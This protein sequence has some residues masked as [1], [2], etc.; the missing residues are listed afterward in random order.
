MTD[1]I[2]ISDLTKQFE[3]ITAVNDVS[4]DVQRGEVFG[5][6]GPNAAGKSTT[7]KIAAT[8]L[9]PT[10]GTISVEGY[11]VL[12]APVDVRS[13]T[14]LLPEDG[15][16]THYDRLSAYKNLEYFGR[17]YDVPEEKLQDRIERLLEFLELSDRRDDSPATFSTGL[18]QKLSLARSMIHNPRVV[19]L[20]EPT[21]SLDPIMSKRVRDFIDEQAEVGKQTFFLCTHLLSEVEDLCDRVGF[22]SR[23]VLVEVGRP[24]DLRRKFWTVRT[25]EVQLADADLSKGR[26]IISSTGLVEAARVEKERVVFEVEEAETKNPQ[27]IRAL[28]E[29]DQ[30]IVEFRE[31]VPDLE[32]VYLKV[33]GGN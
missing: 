31:R 6:L 4:L 11:D 7:V 2:E 23:G 14:G 27:I 9:E 29:S 1:S 8:L 20:D 24:K 17:L 12:E 33:I 15:A 21:S 13:V 19:F 26:E 22:I 18:K 28:M 25:Y 30:L 3:K 32:D 16:N 5:F 10:K